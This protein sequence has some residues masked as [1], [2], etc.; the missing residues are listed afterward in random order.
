MARQ[1]TRSDHRRAI[2][3]GCSVARVTNIKM[4]ATHDTSHRWHLA[5]PLRATTEPFSCWTGGGVWLV[6]L[7]PSSEESW[8][9]AGIFR[10]GIS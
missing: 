5:G 9:E 8:V 7:G 2:F 6:Q 1:G 10:T 3:D 4:R